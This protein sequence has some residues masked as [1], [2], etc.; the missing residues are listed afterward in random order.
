MEFLGRFNFPVY[1]I[2]NTLGNNEFTL[3]VLES[4]SNELATMLGTQ[5]L[6]ELIIQA[7]FEIQ[8]RISELDTFS[9]LTPKL[10]IANK[11][12]L[13]EYLQQMSTAARQAAGV[14]YKIY[15]QSYS[16]FLTKLNTNES[17]NTAKKLKELVMVRTNPD[18]LNNLEFAKTINK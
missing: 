12:E 13:R 18:I 7:S 10:P 9:A 16:A 8:K 14:S 1:K 3:G 15:Q 17:I 11:A 4:T 6:Y 2:F 5:I